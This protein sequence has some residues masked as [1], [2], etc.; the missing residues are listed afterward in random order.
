MNGYRMVAREP[1]G[2]MSFTHW[3]GLLLFAGVSYGVVPWH[4]RESM[5]EADKLLGAVAVITIFL[6]TA[7]S[8]KTRAS[9]DTPLSRFVPGFYSVHIEFSLLVMMSHCLLVGVM[10][11]PSE[12][13]P[14]T[15]LMLSAAMIGLAVGFMVALVAQC[16]VISLGSALMFVQVLIEAPLL[17]MIVSLLVF[18]CAAVAFGVFVRQHFRAGRRSAP[19]LQRVM[20]STMTGRIDRWFERHTPVGGE[21]GYGVPALCGWVQPMLL[22]GG[23]VLCLSLPTFIGHSART[24]F[25]VICAVAPLMMAGLPLTGLLRGG[26]ELSR[27]W[28]MCQFPTRSQLLNKLVIVTFWQLLRFATFFT[29]YLLL[30]TWWHRPDLIVVVVVA[31][32]MGVTSAILFSG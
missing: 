30:L 9:V 20:G 1:F 7:V 10:C 26:E 13:G 5:I 23:L 3:V 24:Y 28:L 19:L 4:V 25:F 12:F 11:G 16:S 18:A 29:V 8:A 31:S 15:T 6:A 17:S 27:I 21:F 14:V 32:V 22:A 2:S